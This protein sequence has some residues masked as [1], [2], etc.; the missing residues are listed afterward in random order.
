MYREYHR[1]IKWHWI[2]LELGTLAVGLLIIYLGV[3]W[4]KNEK[5]LTEKSRSLLPRQ[6]G[7]FLESKEQ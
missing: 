5:A 7:E 2:Y 1:Y 4:Q 6:L 3:L